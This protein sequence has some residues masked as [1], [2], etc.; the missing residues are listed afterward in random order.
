M[1]KITGKYRPHAKFRLRSGHIRPIFKTKNAK[2]HTYFAKFCT[3]VPLM[4]TPTIRKTKICILKVT[5]SHPYLSGCEIKPVFKSPAFNMA[6][7]ASALKLLWPK[8]TKKLTCIWYHATYLTNLYCQYCTIIP[9]SCN[10][11]A[12][13]YIKFDFKFNHTASLTV[14]EVLQAA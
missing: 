8:R 9:W 6:T 3:R 2:K 14:Q 4:F 10:T 1:K 7:I 12:I 11:P 5:P 13:K